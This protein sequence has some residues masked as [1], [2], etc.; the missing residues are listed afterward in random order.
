MRRCCDAPTSHRILI[1]VLQP[2]KHGI[3][4][5][6][7]CDGNTGYLF[8]FHVYVGKD[9]DLPTHDIIMNSLR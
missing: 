3:K 7:L 9:A 2:I 8:N 5:Y 1:R 6:T 4:I